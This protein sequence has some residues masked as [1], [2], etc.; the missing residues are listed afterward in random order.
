MSLRAL[1]LAVQFLPAAHGA[2]ELVLALLEI[3]GQ[4]VEAA[5]GVLEGAD[6]R[7][8]VELRLAAAGRRLARG[9]CRAV[10]EGLDEVLVGEVVERKGEAAARAFSGGRVRQHRGIVCAWARHGGGLPG[11]HGRERAGTRE[12]QLPDSLG[13]CLATTCS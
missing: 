2:R 7:L 1:Q 13:E 11:E 9:R 6:Q 3:L 5:Q 12:L 4:V 8:G 10:G